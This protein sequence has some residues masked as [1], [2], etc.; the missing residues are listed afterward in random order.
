MSGRR[1]SWTPG[2]PQPSLPVILPSEVRS[3]GRVTLPSQLLDNIEWLAPSRSSSIE[4]ILEVR[5][6]GHVRIVPKSVVDALLLNEPDLQTS[7]TRRA[8]ATHVDSDRRLVLP[9]LLEGRVFPAWSRGVETSV[10]LECHKDHVALLTT[11][12]WMKLIADDRD[13]AELLARSADSS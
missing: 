12:S 6:I 5:S 1:V 13:L 3:K 2:D 8:L 7:L 10:I 4:V 11:E 9:T